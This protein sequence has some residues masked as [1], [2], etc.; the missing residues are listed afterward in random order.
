TVRPG[1]L[2][3]LRFRTISN[4]VGNCTGRSPGRAAQDAIHISGGTTVGIYLVDSV[5]EQ[6]AVSGKVRLV[7]DRRYIVSGGRRYDRRA[8]RGD[9]K[10]RRDDKATSRLATKGDDGCFDLCVGMNGGRD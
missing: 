8:M 2:A 1:A 5:G 7:K 6:A 10:I 4:L 3:V 9:E